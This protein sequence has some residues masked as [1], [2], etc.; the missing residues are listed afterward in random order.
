M[1]CHEEINKTNAVLPFSTPTRCYA[2][3]EHRRWWSHPFPR[4]TSSFPAALSSWQLRDRAEPLGLWRCRKEGGEIMEWALDFLPSDPCL[5]MLNPCLQPQ[6]CTPDS[7]TR[8]VPCWKIKKS[9]SADHAL[10]DSP[11][12][13]LCSSSDNSA[14][15]LTCDPGH[16]GLVS[17][18][19]VSVCL[20]LRSFLWTLAP[21]LSKTL[22]E[23][24][25]PP[26]FWPLV[27]TG[28]LLISSCFAFF[29]GLICLSIMA[30]APE[31]N[32]PQILTCGLYPEFSNPTPVPL[33][34]SSELSLCDKA[35]DRERHPAC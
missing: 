32:S 24:A 5:L 15:A 20:S 8:P 14:F 10:M 31:A 35:T 26:L 30:P 29:W 18:P 6:P 23:A 9:S 1:S 27:K 33:D 4:L 19:W 2:Q 12:L 34:D 17:L 13:T 25:R 7:G 3:E 28:Y 21:W 11:A 22:L 16:P